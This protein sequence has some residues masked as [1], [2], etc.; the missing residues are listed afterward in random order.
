MKQKILLP[1]I[2]ILV[3]LIIPHATAQTDNTPPQITSVSP[4]EGSIISSQIPVIQADYIDDSRINI[5][6]VIIIVDNIDVTEWEET[7]IKLNQVTYQV[8]EIFKLRNGNHTITVKVS[9]MENNQATK[10]WN[11]TVDTSLPTVKE[12]GIDIQTMIF[13]IIIGSIIFFFAFIIFILYLKKTRRFTFKKYFARHP[14]KRILI[15]LYIPLLISF[16]FVLFSVA[17]I[18]NT[19]HISPFSFEYIFIIGIII[20]LL[21]YAID[22]QFNR[23]KSDKYERAFAQFLFEMAD[24]MRGGLD[25]TKAVIELSKTHEGIL[26][27]QLRK[28]SDNIQLGRPFDEVMDSMARP[29]KSELIKR[30]A[31]LIGDTSKVGGETSQ[32]IYRAAKDMDDFIKINQERRRQLTAQTT[33][34][35]IAFAVL[36]IILYMLISMF[37][38]IGSMD[39]GLL[40][41][42]D[43]ENVGSKTV[44]RMSSEIMKRRFF[45]LMIINSLG[46]GTVIGAFIDGKIK[47]GLI[48][49]I[50][51]IISS[52]IFFTLLIL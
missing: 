20:A 12:K 40:G 26:K 22:A 27:T 21:P 10:T 32:V 24:A 41:Q 50:I 45:H 42:T 6:S 13:Y 33:T 48:H 47:Y 18:N 19:Q 14:I 2:L 52:V 9:D 46:T 23:R 34:I 17:I 30:Y 11:F 16:F 4:K 35:Y 28:A 31:S 38:S 25:P 49:S 8:P 37:P 15:V 39:L 51:L 43:V 5:K 36:L 7:S 29:L 1:I 44:T 3:L